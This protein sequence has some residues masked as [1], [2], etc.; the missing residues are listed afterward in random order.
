[1]ASL[2]DLGLL[3]PFLPLFVFFLVLVIVFALLEKIEFFPNLNDKGPNPL[4]ALIAFLS[5]VLF[6]LVP[7]LTEVVSIVTPWFVMLV[8]FLLMIVLVFLFMGTKSKHIENAFGSG[9]YPA[10]MWFII[11][12]SLGIFGLAFSQVFGEQVQD[13]TS[14]G[15]DGEENLAGS[16]GQIIFTPK[17]MSMMLLLIISGLVVRFISQTTGTVGWK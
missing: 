2:F 7:E 16:V 1:M 10:I 5:A 15:P 14:P 4:N 3:D 12:A 9:E 6:I 17:V 8:L 13:I 11:L